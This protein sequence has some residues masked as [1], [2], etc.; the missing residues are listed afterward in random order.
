[1]T[2]VYIIVFSPKGYN[3]WFISSYVYEKKLSRTI[4][5][6]WHGIY[7]ETTVPYNAFKPMEKQK[8]KLKYLYHK[9]INNIKIKHVLFIYF[10][11]YA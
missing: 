3:I 7:F 8:F 1:M 2:F 9:Y 11:F 5:K 10:A 6:V 4:S